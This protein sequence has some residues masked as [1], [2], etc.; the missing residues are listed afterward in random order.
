MTKLQFILNFVYI[1][2]SA[3]FGTKV[4]IRSNKLIKRLFN[5]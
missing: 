2:M 1:L 5:L 3:V 4:D